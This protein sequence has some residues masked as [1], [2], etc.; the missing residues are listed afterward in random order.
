[1]SAPAILAKLKAAGVR[2]RRRGDNLLAEPRAAIT[3]P[4][5][6][7]MRAHKGELLAALPDETTCPR[8]TIASDQRAELRTL[9]DAVADF[10]GFT[11]E[12][13]A[14]AQQIAQGDQVAALECFRSQAA[15]LATDDR[16]KCRQCSYLRGRICTQ[17]ALLGA[18]RGY[19]PILEIARRCEWFKPLAN[20][21][22]QRTG[23]Q[24]WPNRLTKPAIH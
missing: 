7:L 22:D 15:K 5:L 17:A 12:Q 2:V 18:G 24:R 10:H 19:A 20:A 6:V 23:A 1:M 14:E 3:E 13:T 9:V 11:L 21:E 16:I 4:L 8:A